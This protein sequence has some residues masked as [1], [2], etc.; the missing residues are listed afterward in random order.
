MGALLLHF[1]RSNPFSDTYL[2][3]RDTLVLGNTL[4][5]NSHVEDL[6]L[7]TRGGAFFSDALFHRLGCTHSFGYTITKKDTCNLS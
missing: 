6:T 7:C 5:Y 3:L 2:D 1:S 4:T